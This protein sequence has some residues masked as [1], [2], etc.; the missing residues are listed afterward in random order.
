MAIYLNIMISI[1]T[2]SQQFTNVAFD[3]GSAD[4][5]VLSSQS[6]INANYLSYYISSDSSTYKT[7]IGSSWNIA[8]AGKYDVIIAGLMAESQIFAQAT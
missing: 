1:G 2:S 4:L 5:W 6:N 7:I 8:Y 3:T